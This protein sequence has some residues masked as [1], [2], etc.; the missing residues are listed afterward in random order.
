MKLCRT[1]TRQNPIR[2]DQ[3]HNQQ[4]QVLRRRRR[5]QNGQHPQVSYLASRMQLNMH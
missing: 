4:K 1:I 5:Q 3:Q 2:R